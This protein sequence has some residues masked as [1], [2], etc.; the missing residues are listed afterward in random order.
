MKH[1][2]LASRWCRCGWLLCLSA[3]LLFFA[4]RPAWAQTESRLAGIANTAGN[5]LYHPYI[6][7]NTNGEQTIVEVLNLAAIPVEFL[8]HFYDATG[9][10]AKTLDGELAPA[11]LL[12]I[13]VAALSG[14]A[15]EDHTLTISA[16]GPIATLVR[17]ATPVRTGSTVGGIGLYQGVAHGCGDG[18]FGPFY[19]D[20][21]ASQLALTNPGA[22][23]ADVHLSFYYPSG[24]LAIT[25]TV[26]ITPQGMALIALPATLPDVF[27][28]LVTARSNQPVVGLLVQRRAR[29]GIEFLP[30]QTAY[31]LAA[32]GASQ[33]AMHY[34][35][36]RLLYDSDLG[37]GVRSTAIFIGASAPGTTTV[38]IDSFFTSGA[39]LGSMPPHQLA[40]KQ[41]GFYLPPAW[42]GGLQSGL[43]GASQPLYMVEQTEYQ[44]PSPYA[45][46]GYGQAGP[47]SCANWLRIPY[48]A[49]Q[50]KRYSILYIQN[51]DRDVAPVTVTYRDRTGLAVAA[52]DYEIEAKGVHAFDLRTV[53]EL[54]AG[55]EGSAEIFTRTRLLCTQ[56]DE[57]GVGQWVNPPSGGRQHQLY[58]PAIQTP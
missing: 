3:W 14:L 44:A 54:P 38:A 22:Q 46:A 15:D 55:F 37:G 51:V 8:A 36:P 45:T 16:T 50:E 39:P 52:T 58:L 42:M 56:V 31:T 49:V 57:Y 26:E 12:P 53:G 20:D 43:V 5:V 2:I 30:G 28:G 27:V 23:A 11:Q 35:V 10:L 21:P 17:V 32:Q 19:G 7:N 33:P 24:S 34:P 47:A 48:L 18:A 6:P 25:S 29:D 4:G 1:P 41:N 9:K 13:D 40:D